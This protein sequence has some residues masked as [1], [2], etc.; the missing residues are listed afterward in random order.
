LFTSDFNIVQEGPILRPEIH[1]LINAIVVTD[2][3]VHCA[4]ERILQS[5]WGIGAATNTIAPFYEPEIGI[6][7]R[8]LLHDDPSDKPL[9]SRSMY[10]YGAPLVGHLWHRLRGR[11]YYRSLDGCG[12]CARS[13]ILGHTDRATGWPKVCVV[14]MTVRAPY[15]H[16]YLA[17]LS[18]SSS[19]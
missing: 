14:K 18:L 8:A 12:T 15:H 5:N 3:G 10:N 2:Q 4:H 19:A 9:T 6:P 1:Y 11:I 13:G 16:D 7:L 17:P